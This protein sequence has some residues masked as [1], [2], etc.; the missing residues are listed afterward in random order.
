M[1]GNGEKRRFPLFRKK[2][3]KNL[4]ERLYFLKKYGNMIKISNKR[5]RL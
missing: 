3:F 4:F 5:S 2:I 1:K